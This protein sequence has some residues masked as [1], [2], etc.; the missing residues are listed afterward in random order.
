MHVPDLL[1]P[2]R[3]VGAASVLQVHLQAAALQAF[4]FH[5][6]CS[7]P[8]LSRYGRHVSSCRRIAPVQAHRKATD[9]GSA[10]AAGY[11]SGLSPCGRLPIWAQPM[12]KVRIQQ[13]QAQHRRQPDVQTIPQPRKHKEASRHGALRCPDRQQHHVVDDKEGAAEGNVHGQRD[14]RHAIDNDDVALS[15]VGGAMR[16]P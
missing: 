8:G 5:M 11:R 14:V 2:A 4:H 3:Q 16:G 7:L 6:P 10:H 12:R 15:C 13:A 9:L 1:V